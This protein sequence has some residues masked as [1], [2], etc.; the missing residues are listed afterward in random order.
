MP[1]MTQ[2]LAHSLQSIKLS[3]EALNRLSTTEL[4]NEMKL[5]LGSTFFLVA[6]EAVRALEGSLSTGLTGTNKGK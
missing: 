4:I 3:L 2:L 6:L 1:Y 5:L